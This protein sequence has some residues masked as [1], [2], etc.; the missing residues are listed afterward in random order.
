[1]ATLLFSDYEEWEFCPKW[2]SLSLCG[3]WVGR[4]PGLVGASV[5]TAV[6]EC[7][8]AA[9]GGDG[10]DFQPDHPLFS[11]VQECEMPVLL[12][13]E[14]ADRVRVLLR[15]LTRGAEPPS[16]PPPV[17]PADPEA[18]TKGG[19]SKPVQFKKSQEW[20]RGPQRPAPAETPSQGYAR[21]IPNAEHHAEPGDHQAAGP[22]PAA[23]GRGGQGVWHGHHAGAWAGGGSPRFACL[24]TFSRPLRP[25][26][27]LFRLRTHTFR[28]HRPLPRHSSSPSA[29][30]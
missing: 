4:G 18:S 14:G 7:G 19:A 25:P 16:P 8:E 5:K 11:A 30:G 24:F 9:L 27:P 28:S 20:V 23:L 21:L 10:L 26:A 29:G 2:A 22:P 17:A 13:A 3:A 1:M 12:P 15:F 6:P